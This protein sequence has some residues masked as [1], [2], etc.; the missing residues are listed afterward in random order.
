MKVNV[1]LYG[2][3]ALLLIG[4][5]LAA[6]GQTHAGP[7]AIA[8]I[9]DIRKLPADE[10]IQP[11][12]QL[13]DIDLKVLSGELAG[14]NATVQHEDT[15]NQAYRLTLTKGDTVVIWHERQESGEMT[16]GIDEFYKSQRI[17]ILVFG[18][19]GLIIL[20][21]GEKGFKA[22]M[23]LGITLVLIFGVMTR[24]LVQGTSPILLGVTISVLITASNLLFIAGWNRKALIAG[25]GTIGGVLTAGLFAW[26][27]TDLLHLNGFADHESQ[28]LQMLATSLDLRG[29]LVCGMII[30]VLGAVMDVAISI[31][32]SIQEISIANPS[33]TRHDLFSA[34]MRIGRDII[35]SMTNTLI[36]AYTG[37]SLTMILVFSLQRED[38][39]LLKILNMEFISA[40]ILRSLA[41]LFGMVLAIPLTAAMGAALLS[42]PGSPAGTTRPAAPPEKGTP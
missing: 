17:L 11:D 33:Y 23:A 25:I 42:T 5:L 4:A 14:Q 3:G 35:G 22:L 7:F 21:T 39:P 19:I 2:L 18:L 38:F 26:L 29:I 32:S 16:I 37:A 10:T 24:F 36:L 6:F 31:A 27:A 12:G 30:G 9:L 41:G 15:P 20:L 40:E 34:G 8:T 13:F 1:I 28:F